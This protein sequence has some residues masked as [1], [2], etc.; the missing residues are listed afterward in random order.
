MPSTPTALSEH[1][2]RRRDVALAQTMLARA[3]TPQDQARW[4]NMLAVAQRNVLAAE[5]RAQILPTPHTEA[6]K[7]LKTTLS[8]QSPKVSP[9]HTPQQLPQ[10]KQ[11]PDA[12][13]LSQAQTPSPVL[14]GPP[15]CTCGESIPLKRRELGYRTCLDCGSA[16]EQFIIMEVPKSNAVVT[17]RKSNL[18]GVSGSHKGR[19]FA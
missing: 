5:G 12:P 6:P 1:E 9:A 3:T 7:P 11:A 16:R 15:V 10:A 13:A 18:L 14:M 17:S 4:G 8:T 2:Q 19:G